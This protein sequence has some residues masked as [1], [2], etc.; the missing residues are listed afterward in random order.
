MATQKQIAPLQARFLYPYINKQ[1]QSEHFLNTLA[2]ATKRTYNESAKN[3]PNQ[4]QFQLALPCHSS[5]SW[6]PGNPSTPAPT[7]NDPARF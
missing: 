3:K 5:E 4:T 7:L 6:N 1:T 2:A